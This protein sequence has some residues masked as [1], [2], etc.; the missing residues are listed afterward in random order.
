MPTVAESGFPGFNAPAWWGLLAP[1][2][3][4]PAIVNAMNAAVNKA[5][6]NP[7]VSE[8]FK[9]QGIQI[10]GGSPEVLGDFVGKQ[11]AIWG[12]FVIENNIK[13]SQ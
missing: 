4:P 5:L 3:T 6:K 10:V 8:K 2:K 9:A 1:G 11:I 12:K 13:D 7:A